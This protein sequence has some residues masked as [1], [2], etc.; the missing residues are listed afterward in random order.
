MKTVRKLKILFSMWSIGR[1]GVTSAFCV[2]ARYLESLGYEVKVVHDCRRRK[3][4]ALH[5]VPERYRLG[6]TPDV[7]SPIR[8][9]GRPWFWLNCLLDWKLLFCRKVAWDDYDYD[10]FVLF[11][12]YD[13]N[14]FIMRF[15]RKKPSIMWLHEVTERPRENQS[16]HAGLTNRLLKWSRDKAMRGFDEYVAVS[17]RAAETQREA[18]GLKKTPKVIYNLIDI[19]DID[20]KA[21]MPQDD[22]AGEENVINIIYLGR[23]SPEKGV[24]RLIDAVSEIRDCA[25]QFRLWIVGKNDPNSRTD[26]QAELEN[27]VKQRGLSDV[28]TFLGEKTNPYPYLKACDLMVLP[29]RKEGMGIV[30]WEALV[31]GTPV[32]ATDSGGPRE[33][34]N[35]GK[36]GTI[37]E[38]STE[39]IKH[40]ILEFLEGRISFDMN[41][42]RADVITADEENRQKIKRLF[43]EITMLA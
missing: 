5:V 25:S 24:D 17:Q 32:I 34:L 7:N 27:L 6:W 1:G 36:W 13:L 2:L 19:P 33:A 15:A 20:E 31:C 23:L 41:K 43:D 12:G 29:S 18:K 10:C 11:N 28:V 22:I 4:S 40:G 14:A 8:H 35:N 38:N 39:G 42:I 16:R 30:I 26:L 37:V 3:D 9:A 21:K